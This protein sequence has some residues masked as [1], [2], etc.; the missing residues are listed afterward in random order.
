MTL[1]DANWKAPFLANAV[2]ISSATLHMDN[3]SL[4]WDP[5][6]FSYGPV[7]GTATLHIRAECN[8]P[9]GCP[10]QLTIRF[11]ALDG[12][13][14]QAALLG[15]REKGTLLSTLLDR[16]SSTTAPA[17]PQLQGTAT[18]DSL[19]LGPFT[20]NNVS[21][22]IKVKSA[23]AEA[24]SFDAGMLGGHVHGTATLAAGDKPDY[25]T[26]AAFTNVNPEQAGQ[27]AGVKCSGGTIDGHGKLELTGYT[28]VD[29]GKSARGTV[30]FEWRHGAVAGPGVPPALAR[31]DRW[32]GDA[33]LAENGMSL[34][35]SETQRG[36]AKV[37]VAAAVTFG[38]PAKVSFSPVA[39]AA[40]SAGPTKPAAAP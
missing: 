23:S 37:P 17:W 18:A 31:F 29:L 15:A 32:S 33:T 21:A 27:L 19:S 38:A 5:V 11:G 7:K 9:L 35:D 25:T 34:K 26:E 24:T 36:S 6:Q 40:A 30:H 39:P 13:V 20:L 8:D 22:E 2:L 10:P 16:L 4:S 3:G 1:R 14:L 28:D 12:E